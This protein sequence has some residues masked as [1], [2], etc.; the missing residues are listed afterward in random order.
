[1]LLGR[2]KPKHRCAINI[3][4]ERWTLPNSMKEARDRDGREAL[5]KKGNYPER[6]ESWQ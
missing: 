5:E 4:K 1:M 6:T 2:K 3:G